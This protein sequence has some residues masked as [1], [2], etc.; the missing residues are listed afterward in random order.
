MFDKEAQIARDPNVVEGEDLIKESAI[1]RIKAKIPGLKEELPEAKRYLREETPVRG[2]EFFNVLTGVRVQPVKNKLEA[3]FTKL[4]V[5]PYS[6]YGST[7]DKVYD[8][9]I[10]ENTYPFLQQVVVPYIES[11]RYK[12]LTSAQKK[13]GLTE[14]MRIALEAGRD[15]T[16]GEMMAEDISRVNKMKFNKLSKDKRTAINE[17][18][19][20]DTGQTMDEAKAYDRVDEYEARLQEVM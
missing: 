18:Y 19:K 15:I 17:M 4:N 10:I 8:R 5:D 11:D 3:E 14:Y 12:N 1:N 9:T 16:Q 6:V 2:G 13:I 7:G 20:K